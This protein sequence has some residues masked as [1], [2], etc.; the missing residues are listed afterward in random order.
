MY[1][2]KIKT[3][4]KTP[5]CISSLNRSNSM[6]RISSRQWRM[7]KKDQKWAVRYHLAM[8]SSQSNH[9]DHTQSPLQLQMSSSRTS[10]ESS[11]QAEIEDREIMQ[12]MHQ[13]INSIVMTATEETTT[14]KTTTTKKRAR[15]TEMKRNTTAM[16]IADRMIKPIRDCNKV[17]WEAAILDSQITWEEDEINCNRERHSCE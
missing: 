5:I 17:R 7:F 15:A 12:G 3:N 16:S 2:Y 6:E 10:M 4:L 13:Q 14:A 1:N 8:A 11:S 9:R